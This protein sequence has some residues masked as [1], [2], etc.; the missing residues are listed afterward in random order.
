VIGESLIDRRDKISHHARFDDISDPP[1][2]EALMD[3]SSILMDGQEYLI[4]SHSFFDLS[5]SRVRSSRKPRG[6]YDIQ[7]KTRPRRSSASGPGVHISS[8]IQPKIRIFGHHVHDYAPGVPILSANPEFAQDA[9][10][11]SNVK[12]IEPIKLWDTR[13][14]F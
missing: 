9:S 1:F 10:G 13:T 4:E 6:S 3:E 5:A 7:G 12:L 8:V 2:S 11:N 14:W